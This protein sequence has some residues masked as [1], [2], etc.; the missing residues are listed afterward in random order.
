MKLLRSFGKYLSFRKSESVND[1]ASR[2]E[3]RERTYKELDTDLFEGALDALRSYFTEVTIVSSTTGIPNGSQML[4]RTV[5]ADD[6]LFAITREEQD[7]GCEIKSPF[8]P[9]WIQGIVLIG[10]VIPG[11][12]APQKRYDEGYIP[13][14]IS[15]MLAS[16]QELATFFKEGDYDLRL[17]H[18]IEETRAKVAAEWNIPVESLPWNDSVYLSSPAERFA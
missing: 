18:L 7:F 13:W 14:C 16:W 17:R 10:R 3:P 9:E 8:R 4:Q 11:Q 1:V 2:S 12:G 5:K 15:S 6:W